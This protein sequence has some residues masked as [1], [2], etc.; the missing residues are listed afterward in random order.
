MD[1]RVRKAIL[2]EFAEPCFATRV[3]LAQQEEAMSFYKGLAEPCIYRGAQMDSKLERTWA[4]HLDSCRIEWERSE[5]AVD[6]Y[7][8]DFWLPQTG[9]YLEVKPEEF[10]YENDIFRWLRFVQI[11]KAALLIVFG[12]PGFHRAAM[13][14]ADGVYTCPISLRKLLLGKNRHARS[15]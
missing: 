2:Q 1:E 11:K 8:P 6:V 15:L 3:E 4:M 13:L 7:R 9:H 10:D 12:S 5:E 14:E